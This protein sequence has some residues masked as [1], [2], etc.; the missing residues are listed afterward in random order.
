MNKFVAPVAALAFAFSAALAHADDATGKV[1]SV[2]AQ[3]Q[4]L[5]LEDGTSF[6]ISE[7]VSVEGLEPGTE[8]T[9]SYEEQDGQKVATEVAPAN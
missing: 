7:G 6:M 2:D 9:V 8:V 1:A 3:S 4:T 5:I